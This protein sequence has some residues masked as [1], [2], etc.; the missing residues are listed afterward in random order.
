MYTYA[1][2]PKSDIPLDLPE[3]ISG[4]LQ[5]ITVDQVAA[6]VEPELSVEALQTS[7]DVLMRAVLYHDQVIRE[8]FEQ[9]TVLPLRFGTCFISRQ[10]LVEHLGSHSAKYYHKLSQLK[11]RAEY[12]LKL[13]P[14]EISEAA[15]S[16]ELKGKDYFLAK[17]Q[18]YQSQI[19][20]QQQQQLELEALKTTISRFY[21]EWIHTDPS[22]G[23]ERIYLL[24]DRQTLPALY[25]Y[26]SIWQ[27]QCPHWELSLGEALPPYHFV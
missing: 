18:R 22:D 5:L 26:V 11:G 20:W 6:L 8:V 27:A 23:V 16:P 4:S 13:K 1:F 17:R 10:G 21:P 24:S 25:E 19:D 15:I 3:G 9:I 7:D 14:I 2:L 12:L